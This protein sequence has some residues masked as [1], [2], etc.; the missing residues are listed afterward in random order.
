MA[1]LLTERCF[2]LPELVHCHLPIYCTCDCG[3]CQVIL[4]ATAGVKWRIKSTEDKTL[5]GSQD[6]TLHLKMPNALPP[7]TERLIL[8]R[9]T[10]RDAPFLLDLV[11][12][13]GWLEYIGD[14]GVH[15]VAGAEQYIQERILP[16]YQNEGY[17]AMLV[18]RKADGI[19]LGNVGVYSRPGLELPDF[20]FAFLLQFQ[21]KG[22]AYEASVSMLAHARKAGHRELLAIT[23]PHNLPSLRLLRKLG[24]SEEGKIQMP[25]D[26]ETLLLLRWKAGDK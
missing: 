15:D 8:R 17:G 7:P 26:P 4:G 23:L 2:F 21:G 3:N 12:S 5:V 18:I 9:F 6:Y 14:R 22:Y 24:F 10:L 20:G 25:N 13:P 11:N 16:S 19:T 1:P